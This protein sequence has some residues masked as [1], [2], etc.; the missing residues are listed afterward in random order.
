MGSYISRYGFLFSELVKRD[1]KHKYK[2][3]ILG[4]LW[5]VLSPLMHL[6]VMNLVF[7]YFFKKKIEHYTVFMF[8]GNI[9]FS[10]YKEATTQGMKALVGNK[11]IISKINVPKYLFLLSNNVSSLINF[12]LTFLIFLVFVIKEPLPITW[13]YVLL[14]YPIGCLVVFNIGVGL[15]LSA[16]FVFFKDINYLYGV[17]TQLLMYISAIFYAVESYPKGVRR[18]FLFNPVYCY[19]KYFRV[20]VLE[21]KV[22]SLQYHLLCIGYAA[23]LIVIGSL[24]Y[25]KY[26]NRFIYYM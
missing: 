4:M 1:F 16:L 6:A 18:L 14:F 20:V 8:S 26:N 19:I 24:I 13:K 25:R 17:F 10:Y 3:T 23:A 11:G 2:G 21:D 9:I 7:S 15:I 5:S 12:G 22:P